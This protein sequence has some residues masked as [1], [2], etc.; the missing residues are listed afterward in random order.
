M[1]SPGSAYLLAYLPARRV[2]FVA[3]TELLD[4]NAATIDGALK[5]ALE[6]SRAALK[7]EESIVAETDRRFAEL[8]T[9]AGL[10]IPPMP[11]PRDLPKWLD[12]LSGHVRSQLTTPLLHGAW[13]AGETARLVSLSVQLLAH[14]AYLRCAAAGNVDL[15]VQAEHCAED[16]TAAATQ[17]TADL[18]ALGLPL[19]TSQ[20]DNV[21]K[22]VR[23]T[24]NLTP[25]TE[26][27][28]R[29]INELSRDLDKFIE[30]KVRQ[31]DT[32]P[33]T[34]SSSTPSAQEQALLV[35][36]IA[37]PRNRDLR[38][39][40]AELVA[41]RDPDRAKVIEIQLDVDGDER[42][43]TDL[44]LSHPEWTARLRE[45]G[46]RDIKF[47]SGFP[48]TITVDASAFLT[49]GAEILAAAPITRVLVR[50]A[51][52][53]VGE[54]VR[55][56][57]LA[58]LRR[59]DLDDQGVTDDDV[60]ALASSPHATNLEQLDLRFSVLT[61]RGIEAIAASK[62]LPRLTRVHLDG[63]P[64]D[65]V[66]RIEYVDATPHV[67]ATDAGQALEAKYGPLRWL[68]RR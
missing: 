14:I 23:L 57:L 29:Q 52:G 30:L 21:E 15:R 45:L 28:Y 19:V 61:A 55:S 60:I 24:R 39:Q 63:N 7:V 20:A 48:D 33:P 42:E 9:T 26:G 65:P 1:L 38:K 31:L 18:K 59:L 56:P 32:A 8:A 66:D 62:Q 43:A 6:F 51:D 37:D 50:D 13:G 53:R 67:V 41:D 27:G 46:A 49:R 2:A 54:I 35:Q 17:L 3:R 10:A 36:I 4:R 5:K 11:A 34:T 68:R 16:L 58:N 12:A 22:M 44:I 47:L 25:T 40:F 64:E